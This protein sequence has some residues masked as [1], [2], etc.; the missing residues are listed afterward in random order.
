LFKCASHRF[1]ALTNN[2]G[3]RPG[4]ADIYAFLGT[5]AGHL[6][7]Y[8][9]TR[10]LAEKSHALAAEIG[11]TWGLGY[12]LILLGGAALA[13]GDYEEAGHFFQESQAVCEEIGQQETVGFSVCYSAVVDLRLRRRSRARQRLCDALRTANALEAFEPLVYLLAAVALLL[14]DMGQV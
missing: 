4:L 8:E 10:A 7:E 6:G 2:L 11:Y 13:N 14:A 5:V 3:Y 1:G 12:S 9:S